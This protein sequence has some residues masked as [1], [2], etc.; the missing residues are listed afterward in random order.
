[1]HIPPPFISGNPHDVIYRRPETKLV[2]P[3]INDLINLSLS[4][5]HIYCNICYK[6]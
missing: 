6:L 5:R 3:A 1:M 4:V 2:P